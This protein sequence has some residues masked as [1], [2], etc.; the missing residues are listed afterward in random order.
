MKLVN[1]AKRRRLVEI[2][3]DHARR[4]HS[5]RDC[6]DQV[7][8][9]DD[10]DSPYGAG[11]MVRSS[12]LHDVQ[13][14]ESRNFLLDDAVSVPHEMI[15]GDELQ[16]EIQSLSKQLL[17]AK[18]TL[19][20]AAER[21]A[22]AHN[23]L[24]IRNRTAKTTARQ[25]FVE[26]RRVCNPFECLGE[27][28]GGGLNT[29]FM[30]RSAIKLANIDAMLDFCISKYQN[31]G[32]FLFADLCGAPGG[33]SEY[34]MRRCIAS[35]VSSCRGYGLSLFGSN[36]YGSGA[37]WK[38]GD[39]DRDQGD[40]HLQYRICYGADGTGDIF[41]WGNV[42]S[43]QSDI[44]N[45]SSTYSTNDEE[46]GKVH[47]VLADG[48]FDAQRDAEDQEGIAQK[49]IVCEVGAALCLLQRGGT[50]AVKL[51]GFQAEVTKC[52]LY[53]IFS[54]FDRMVAVKPISSRPASA[55]RYVVFSGFKGCPE[56]WSGP[57][58]CDQ[59]FLGRLDRQKDDNDG[60]RRFN[61]Y[62][63]TFDRDILSLNLKACC[64]VLDYLQAQLTNLAQTEGEP[65]QCEASNASLDVEAYRWA[66][67]L[68]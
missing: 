19:S 17:Q 9:G 2:S 46:T 26:A 58:W 38:L 63:S 18:R 12:W 39:I 47:L 11:I 62:L 50:L 29:L 41:H 7:L 34:I 65:C 64:A 21:C 3:G 57:R 60:T 23:T 66:W 24:S 54:S 8:G 36:E 67:N 42:E 68:F 51:F 32:T 49:L 30:N 52:V 14:I 33:F 1:N 35:R 6:L 31:T 53:S 27:G 16:F 45:D 43:L 37:T 22:Q 20:P 25:Q 15:A 59:M 44:R 13:W 28:Q 56:G 4:V 5:P 48:G 40:T 55:E 61:Q 10:D